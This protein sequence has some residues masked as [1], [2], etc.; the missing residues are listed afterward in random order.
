[1]VSC[2]AAP[3]PPLHRVPACLPACLLV[4]LAIWAASK[5]HHWGH[6]V[7]SAG[8]CCCFTHPFLTCHPLPFSLLP[9]PCPPAARVRYDG[10]QRCSR[11]K[12]AFEDS[13]LKCL[14]LDAY[15]WSR[16]AKEA[17]P[18]CACLPADVAASWETRQEWATPAAG[19][20][21]G[22]WGGSTTLPPGMQARAVQHYA[23]LL[24]QARW[25][26]TPIPAA[27]AGAT[28]RR[29]ATQ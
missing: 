22:A 9:G 8:C 3:L 5:L 15:W 1:V 17:C 18:A 27:A 21:R 13:Q 29:L 19:A 14:V 12:A 16:E 28:P 11:L 6:C 24:E 4:R 20:A 2:T 7:S 10:E 23:H 26:C 25:G